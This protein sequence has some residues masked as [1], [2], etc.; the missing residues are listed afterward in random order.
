MMADTTTSEQRSWN[1]SSIR[2]RDTRPELQLRSLLHGAGFRFRL[3]EKLLLGRPDI[4]LPAYQTAIF[5]H[6]CFWYRHSGCQNATMPSTRPE[7]WYEKFDVNVVRDEHNHADLEVDGWTVLTALEWE[8]KADAEG[9]V[10]RL[11]RKLRED[12]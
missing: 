8:L 12:S 4:V 5:V 7:F 10:R 2:G 9:V 1:M 3:N 6:G 11:S